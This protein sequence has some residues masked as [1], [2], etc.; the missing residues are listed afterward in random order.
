MKTRTVIIGVVILVIGVALLGVG[1]IGALGSLNI[2]RSFTQPH[3]GEFVSAEIVLNSTSDLVVASAASEGGIIH[4]QDLPLV[5]STSIA[6]LAIPAS[7][8]AGGSETYRGLVGDY[9]YVAFASTQPST[10]I[11][12]TSIGSGIVEY[13]ALALVGLLFIVIG[14]IVAVVGAIQKQKPTPQQP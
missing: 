13:G 8:S 3:P 14:I 7:T 1:A 6:S 9:Y 5:S 12:A 4:A 10:T 2:N 11:V